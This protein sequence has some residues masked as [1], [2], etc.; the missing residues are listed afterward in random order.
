MRQLRQL[1]YA[2]MK[3]ER[4]WWP[5]LKGERFEGHIISW[6]KTDKEI[7]TVRMDDGTEKQIEC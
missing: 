5:N 7:A 6:D 1:D 3:G 2:C 4:V